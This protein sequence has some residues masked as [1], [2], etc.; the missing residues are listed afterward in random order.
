[1]TSPSSLS[2]RKIFSLVFFRAL[3]LAILLATLFTAWSPVGIF[4]GGLS[5]RLAA[6]LTPQA[7]E[8]AAVHTAAPPLRIGI[9]S[10]HWGH[11]SGA[12][13]RDA[14]GQVV[15]TEMEVNL[16]IATLAQKMLLD[17]GFQVDLLQEF[18]E[19]L[20]GYRAVALLSIH[21]DSCEYINNDATG[22]KVAAAKDTRDFNRTARLTAC[23][24]DRYAR[25]TGLPFHAGSITPDMTDYHAFGE[26]DTHT[27]AAIIETGFMYLDHDLL[28]NH[29]DI[30][31]KGIVQ[32]IL[33]FVRNESIE[34][35]VFPSATP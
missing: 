5:E 12:V 27:P 16:K 7:E 19:R 13:C 25:E 22:F 2:A 28:V 14:Q 3:G 33:C 10:G 32:G 18:D 26:I 23:L 21:N 29:P 9:V 1:M 31:A 30:V 11:D 8:P 15:L 6:L 4:R 34:P 20:N 17:E 24:V 35:T